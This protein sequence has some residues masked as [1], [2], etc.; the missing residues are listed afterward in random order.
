MGNK[1]AKKE[2][3]ATVHKIFD[4]NAKEWFTSILADSFPMT[5]EKIKSSDIEWFRQLLVGKEENKSMKD[6]DVIIAMQMAFLRLYSALLNENALPKKEVKKD[7]AYYRKNYA[8]KKES[9]EALREV[10]ADDPATAEEL[11]QMLSK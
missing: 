5:P 3:E 10:F 1:E 8:L 2:L 11:L 6:E 7:R 4:K 9:L